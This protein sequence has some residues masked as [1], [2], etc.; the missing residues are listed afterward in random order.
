MNFFDYFFRPR[1][2][3][4]FDGPG[5]PPFGG[6]P[7]RPPIGPP[8]GSTG[9]DGPPTT[10]PPSFTPRQSPSVFAVDP[11]AIRRCTY[12][13]VYL[14]LDN[15]REFWAYLVFVG[16]RSVAGYR[17]TGRRWVY[18]GLDLRDISYFE[19]F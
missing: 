13:F 7:G 2:Q 8:N 3:P 10:P 6:G 1:R 11:G 16:R 18:F 17:W 5:R 15:G 12:R 9:S 19:C 4:Q 14:W